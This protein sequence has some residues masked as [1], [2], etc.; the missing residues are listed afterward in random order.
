MIDSFFWC[1][2]TVILSGLFYYGYKKYVHAGLHQQMQRHAMKKDGLVNQVGLL[3][4]ACLRIKKETEEQTLLYQNLYT[5]MGIWKQR[6]DE[7]SAE[8]A[9]QWLVIKERI[10]L[11]RAQQRELYATKIYEQALLHE[12]VVQATNDLQRVFH[13][14]DSANAYNVRIFN[15][16]KKS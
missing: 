11:K 13:N 6:V 2:N 7:Q 14:K 5:K 1:L 4:D 15:V 8:K 9:Q 16:M 12:I 10:E 3:Q